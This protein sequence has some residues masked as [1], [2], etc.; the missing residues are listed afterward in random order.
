MIIDPPIN[1]PH[2][3][4]ETFRINLFAANTCSPPLFCLFL[5]FNV[6]E[7]T[8]ISELDFSP[9]TTFVRSKYGCVAY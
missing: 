4:T 8:F 3:E 6:K 2:A 9:Q 7:P 1:D 5:V